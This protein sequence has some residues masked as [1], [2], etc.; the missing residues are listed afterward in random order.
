MLCG[1]PFRWSR[2][3]VAICILLGILSP[4]VQGQE[5][6]VPLYS[7]SGELIAPKDYETWV[8]AG[9]NLGL[10]YRPDLPITTAAEAER[11]DLRLFHNIYIDPAAYA[12]FRATRQFPE[13]TIL[14]MELHAAADREPR[15][16][17]SAGVFNGE[18]VGLEV[19]VKNSRRPDG[20][21]TTWAYYDFTEPSDGSKIKQSAPA[22]SDDRCESC[23]HQH[24]DKDNVWVQF[25]PA[26]RQFLR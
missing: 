8:F 5:L 19:A 7:S 26:L 25:Y 12:H 24:A 20:K 10:A 6:I 4:Q 13:P 21:T 1:P 22:F 17:V 18:R 2:A 3:A 14:V 15:G 11:A 23:H 16:V 9:S